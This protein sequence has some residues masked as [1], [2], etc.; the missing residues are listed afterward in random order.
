MHDKY[1]RNL[2]KCH[3]V[4]LAIRETKITTTIALLSSSSHSS[5]IILRQRYKFYVTD[6]PTVNCYGRMFLVSNMR[7]LLLLLSLLMIT[8][9]KYKGLRKE[10]S[11]SILM[12]SWASMLWQHFYQYSNIWRYQSVADSLKKYCKVATFDLYNNG[13][14]W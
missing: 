4:F 10:P 3:I 1:P 9:L 14:P 2:K 13:K 7:L 12:S 11:R 5:W 8:C 6:I